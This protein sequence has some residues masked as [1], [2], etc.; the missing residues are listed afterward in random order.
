MIK[1]FLLRLPE[2]LREFKKEPTLVESIRVNPN[3]QSNSQ[4]Q[5]VIDNDMSQKKEDEMQI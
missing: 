3:E 2:H 1:D 4:V 5:K